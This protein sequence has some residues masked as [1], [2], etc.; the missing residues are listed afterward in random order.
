MQTEKV[1]EI[2]DRII[3]VLGGRC[4]KGEKWIKRD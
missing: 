1:L 3:E 2:I 4:V